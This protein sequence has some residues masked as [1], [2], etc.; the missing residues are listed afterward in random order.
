MR[1]LNKVVFVNSAHVPYAEVKVD[2][3]VHFIGTQGVGKS[4]LLRAILF[5][6][7]ADKMRLGIPKEKKNFDAFYLPFANSYIVYEVMRENGAY[8]VVVTKSMG[9]AAFRFVDAP[10]RKEWFV[11]ERN[12]VAADWSEI[13]VRISDSG[14]NASSL[15]TGYD[16]FRDIIFGNNRKPELLQF[17]KYAI[18]ESAHYQN[19]PR[20]IQNVFLNSKLDADFIKDTIIQSMDDNEFVIDLSYYRNQIETFEQEY[21]DVMLWM[22]QDKN[23][24]VPVRKQAERVIKGYRTLLY[25]K[26]QIEDGRAELNYAEKDARRRFPEL[27]EQ[28]DLLNKE[29]ERYTRLLGEEREKFNRER[30]KLNQQKGSIDADLQKI[31]SKRRYYAQERIEEVI[32]KVS[33]EPALKYELES[34]NKVYHELTGTYDD[35]MGK[36]RQLEQTLDTEFAKFDNETKNRILYQKEELNMRISVLQKKHYEQTDEIRAVYEEKLKTLSDS[37]EMLLEEISTLKQRKTKIKYTV[38]Y[39]CEIECFVYRRKKYIR[40]RGTYEAGGRP[41]STEVGR[42]SGEVGERVGSED[43]DRCAAQ[44]ATGYRYRIATPFDREQQRFFLRMVG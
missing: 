30:D 21:D 10:Y 25:S 31:K 14:Y 23:G 36:Y 44:K 42:G 35:I 12:E 39:Q 6:Y 27:D 2:G 41:F 24:V 38:H 13:R 15:V 43:R 17:R 4:T 20:T 26:K 8:T 28:I 40:A 33:K 19:I 32:A 9:R 37:K 5:F 16:M 3:N 1:Y 34:L 18:V 29:V 7:N 22:K 11:N